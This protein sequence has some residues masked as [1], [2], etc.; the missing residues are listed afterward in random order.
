MP[1]YVIANLKVSDPEQFER[2][3]VLSTAAVN[4]HGGQFLIRGGRF[5]TVE[6]EW[7][8]SRVTMLEF[9]SWESAMAFVRSPEYGRAREARQGAASVQMIVVEGV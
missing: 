1:A 7:N 8:P 5:E 2:Y 9:A 6:G 4:A 3:K